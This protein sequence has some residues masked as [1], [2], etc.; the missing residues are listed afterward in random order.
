MF[1]L[2]IV[3]CRAQQSVVQI[4]RCTHFGLGLELIFART[5]VVVHKE[6]Y[7]H[8]IRMYFVPSVLFLK[9]NMKTWNGQ[10]TTLIEFRFTVYLVNF[11]PCCA[12]ELLFVL[13]NSTL[14]V[15]IVSAHSY[16][17]L[18]WMNYYHGS[19]FHRFVSILSM[20]TK[21]MV[22]HPFSKTMLVAIEC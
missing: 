12:T 14:S 20:T 13:C 10:P 11:T 2:A 18:A 21:K 7:G 3:V 9:L 5:L 1:C 19:A 4:L 15:D 16:N 17:C 22:D 8:L 6:I